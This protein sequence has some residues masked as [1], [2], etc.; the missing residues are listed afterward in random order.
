MYFPGRI[1]NSFVL[2][3]YW[4]SHLLPEKEEQHLSQRNR[5][6]QVATYMNSIVT[7]EGR[8]EH[9]SDIYYIVGT[10][11]TFPLCTML[12]IYLS[13]KELCLKLAPSLWLP[14]LNLSSMYVILFFDCFHQMM[15][16]WNIWN[17]MQLVLSKFSQHHQDL[18]FIQFPLL[19]PT[20]CRTILS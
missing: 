17:M 6:S 20:H 13:L 8:R 1:P 15:R 3:S 16:K 10:S 9:S 4:H 12:S 5:V 19:M 7:W 18:H 11:F 2:E 14:W